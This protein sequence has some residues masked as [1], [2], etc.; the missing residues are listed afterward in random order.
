LEAL[1]KVDHKNIVKYHSTYESS[2]HLYFIMEFCPKGLWDNKKDGDVFTEPE[3][4]GILEQ[5]LSAMIH[6]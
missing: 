5:C 3:A 1:L 2:D 6:Y 4:A